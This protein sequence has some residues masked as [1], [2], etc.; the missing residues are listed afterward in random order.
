MSL[1]SCISFREGFDRQIRGVFIEPPSRQWI[2]RSGV[3]DEAHQLILAFWPLG[4][5][6]ETVPKARWRK[7]QIETIAVTEWQFAVT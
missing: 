1:D 2:G 7:C 6:S 3:E 5:S 4:E